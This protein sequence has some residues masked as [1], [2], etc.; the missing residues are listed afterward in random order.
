MS[1]VK[2]A[3][4]KLNWV[5]LMAAGGHFAGAV[6]DKYEHFFF[7]SSICVYVG[8]RLFNGSEMDTI[9]FIVHW[10]LIDSW[11]FGNL[12]LEGTKDQRF[13]H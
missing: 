10:N 1:F 9:S 8:R 5:I 12:A 3:P 7:K 13:S 11:N 2:D 6:F 4:Q